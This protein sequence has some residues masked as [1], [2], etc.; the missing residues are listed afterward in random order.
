MS[1]VVESLNFY[2]ALGT[3]LLQ[4]ATLFFAV[5]VFLL[6]GEYTKTFVRSHGL[7]VALLAT[8]V[9]SGFTLV[10][11]DVFGFVPCSLCWFQRMF[12]YPQIVLLLIGMYRK[13]AGVALYGIALSI[14]GAVVSLYQHAIQMGGSEFVACPVS[15]GDC[16]QRIVFEFGYV[17]FPLMAFT[18]FVF[19][20]VLYLAYH[21]ANSPEVAK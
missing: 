14:I 9:A 11:S 12:L 7:L 17:T 18:L 1:P 4:M 3:V 6:K 5:D 20:G 2:L 21:R 10:Y 8:I 16:A 13:D 19:L 15:G